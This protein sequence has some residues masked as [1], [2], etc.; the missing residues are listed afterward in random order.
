MISGSLPFLNRTEGIILTWRRYA[1]RTRGEVGYDGRRVFGIGYDWLMFGV[2][3][4]MLA[5]LGAVIFIMV[6]V[7]RR[8]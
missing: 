4:V 3:V 8:R 7:F 5:L 6:N 2:A 1:G